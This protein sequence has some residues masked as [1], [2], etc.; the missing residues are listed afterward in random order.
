MLGKIR[1]ISTTCLNHQ[2]RYEV[3]VCHTHVL[4]V[5]AWMLAHRLLTMMVVFKCLQKQSITQNLLKTAAIRR[6]KLT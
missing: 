6:Y 3:R 5:Q 2:S 1:P 4:I